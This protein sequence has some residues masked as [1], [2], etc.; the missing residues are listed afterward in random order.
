MKKGDSR[1]AAETVGHTHLPAKISIEDGDYMA[2]ASARLDSEQK[3]IVLTLFWK[4]IVLWYG[5]GCPFT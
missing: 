3:K 4:D 2:A 1:A 5:N